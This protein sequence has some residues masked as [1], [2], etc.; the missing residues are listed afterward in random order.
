MTAWWRMK[1]SENECAPAVSIPQARAPQLIPTLD[2]PSGI[3]QGR[4]QVVKIDAT[5]IVYHQLAVIPLR[6]VHNLFSAK[7]IKL[8][9]GM[10]QKLSVSI[11]TGESTQNVFMLT[12]WAPQST[13][14]HTLTSKNTLCMFCRP[15]LWGAHV[16]V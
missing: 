11:H 9:K 15:D 6:R 10:L 7:G 14:F 1:G 4:S 5:T 8:N 3:R 13:S 12:S 2:W 16:V